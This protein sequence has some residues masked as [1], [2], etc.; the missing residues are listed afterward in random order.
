MGVRRRVGPRSGRVGDELALPQIAQELT[1][2]APNAAQLILTSFVM[3]MGVGTLFAGPL[4]DRIGRKPAILI[5]SG[6]S[7]PVVTSLRNVLG[8]ETLLMGFGLD[9]DQIHSPNEKFE[10]AMN[11]LPIASRTAFARRRERAWLYSASPRTS[12]RLT[13]GSPAT[14]P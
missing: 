8:I 3:G 12:A 11:A 5:G 2:D 7:I 6:G 13:T 14:Q 10:Q 1:P 4:S 9:D